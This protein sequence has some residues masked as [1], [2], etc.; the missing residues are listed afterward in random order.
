LLARLYRPLGIIA[1]FYGAKRSGVAVPVMEVD[2]YRVVKSFHGVVK[3]CI[4]RVGES[5]HEAVE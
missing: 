1:T 4:H 5:S 2:G 3:E